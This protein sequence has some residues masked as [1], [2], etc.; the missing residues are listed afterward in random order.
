MADAMPEES[1]PSIALP[2]AADGVPRE[3]MEAAAGEI[4]PDTGEAG[5]VPHMR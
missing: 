4:Q 5:E 1:Q 3:G 2:S